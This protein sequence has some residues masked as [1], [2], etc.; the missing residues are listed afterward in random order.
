MALSTVLRR[1]P[2]LT[3][4]PFAARWGGAAAFVGVAFAV[5]MAIFGATAETPFMF[6]IP[7]ICLTA[8][9]FDGAAGIFATALSAAAAIYFFLG[10]IGSFLVERPADMVNLALFVLVGGFISL[11]V[12]S[13]KNA[14]VWLARALEHEQ[15]ARQRAES[16]ERDRELLVVELRHRVKNDLQRVVSLMELQA[17]HSPEAA[18]ALRQA[19][20][21]IHLIGRLHERLARQNG[22]V[23]V[24]A[25]A[26]LQDLVAEL[27]D[28][29][30]GVRPIGI[31]L[32]AEPVM[33]SVGRTGP[34]GLIINELVTNAVKHAFPDDDHEWAVRIGLAL[35]NG[36]VFLT[37]EDN[38][39]GIA[40]NVPTGTGLKLVRALT[41][42]LEGHFETVTLAQGGTCSTLHIPI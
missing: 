8:L 9:F 4:L 19:S 18:P 38:G 25:P 13:L 34:V 42:Q 17:R 31:F 35:R 20:H 6:F 14:H 12:E 2:S 37:V 7:A 11:L 24:D 26:F 22:H 16:N 3:H 33:L 41:A 29:L 5:R 39:C 30:Q 10:P 21:R 36:E 1:L 23:L 32:D 27:R 40:P 28:E 15:E